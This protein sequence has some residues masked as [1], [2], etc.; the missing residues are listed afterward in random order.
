MAFLND[1][2]R[3]QL[4]EIF[5]PLEKEVKIALF[6][7]KINCESCGD[8]K[9]YIAEMADLSEKLSLDLYDIED[10][11]AYAKE[12]HVEMVP[13]I[14]LLD[15]DGKDYGI[16]Y[17]GIPAGHEINSFITGVLEMGGIG[18]ELPA[19]MLAQI[20]A[21]DKPV[22]IKVFITLSCPHC[23]GAVAKAHKIALLNENVRAEMIEANTFGELSQKFNVSGVPK[24]VFNDSAD[25]TGNQ[26]MEE[27]LKTI[28]A[29]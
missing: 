14:V 18:E 20:K 23:P 6:T 12:L 21:I 16:K 26:P 8:A 24:I 13:A 17:N 1:D 29:L 19:D 11:S 3:K 4:T 9:E 28:A 2:I 22:D 5:N 7:G 25:L 10:D 27:F 15:A